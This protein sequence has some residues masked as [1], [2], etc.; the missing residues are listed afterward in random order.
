[1]DEVAVDRSDFILDFTDSSDSLI[2][3]CLQEDLDY[4]TLSRATEQRLVLWVDWET[5]YFSL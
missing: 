2:P 3:S 4:V 1:M 5:S